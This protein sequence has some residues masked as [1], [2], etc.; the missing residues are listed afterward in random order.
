MGAIKADLEKNPEKFTAWFRLAFGRI[1]E[2]R[3]EEAKSNKQ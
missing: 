3:N 1:R 2:M